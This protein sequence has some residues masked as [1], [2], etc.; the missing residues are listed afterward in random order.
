MD[1]DPSSRSP[2][3]YDGPPARV[4]FAALGMILWLLTQARLD[5]LFAFLGPRMLPQAVGGIL[6][7]L[8]LWPFWWR[9]VE[10]GSLTGR[11]SSGAALAATAAL[12]APF[13]TVALVTGPAWAAPPASAWL[14]TAGALLLLAAMEEIVCRGFLLDILSFGRRRA[15]GVALSSAVFAALHLA[16]DHASAAGIANILLAGVFFALV[17][18]SSGGLA[19]PVAVHWLWNL[20]TGMVFGWSVSG[21]PP[22]PTLF[23]SAGALPWGAFGPEES[24][25]MTLG[26]AAGVGLE[27]VQLRTTKNADIRTNDPDPRPPVTGGRRSAP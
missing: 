15:W 10:P 11:R 16:N 20:V 4:L 24:V 25:L 12:L 26:V 21:H 22:L 13:A 8:I 3:R 5:G 1:G 6:S 17:R 23:T 9:S 27:I 7:T 18:L 14:V 19:W 2:A